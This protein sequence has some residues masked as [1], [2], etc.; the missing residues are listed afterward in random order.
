M[1][2]V[3]FPI[4]GS[5]VS[6]LS[7]SFYK[8]I[9]DVTNAIGIEVSS[10]VILNK[11]INIT[12][13][14]NKSNITNL[15]NDNLPTTVSKRRLIVNIEDEYNEDA[16]MSTVVNQIEN[17]FIFADHD[18]N[19]FIY[20]IF[21]KTDFNFEF[22]YVTPSISEANKIRDM[23]R[24]KLSQARNI[25]HHE[26]EYNIILPEIIEEFIA[27]VHENKKRLQNLS[28]EEYF[29][30][31]STKRVNL[32]TDLSN[33]ENSRIAYFEKQVRIVGTFDFIMPD[34][35]E[36][37]NETNNYKLT[38]NYKLSFDV[39]KG[40]TV[41]Y[42]V[43]VCNRPLKSKYIKFIED[44]K[45][46]S[47]EEYKKEL[48]YSLSLNS[49]SYFE[50]HRLLENRIDIKLPINVP[51]FD[52]YNERSIHKGYGI[53]YTFLVTIDETDKK[54]LLNLKKLGDYIFHPV[55]LKF[56]EDIE[57]DYCIEPY[58]SFIYIGLQ[59]DDFLFNLNVLQITNDLTI[60]SQIELPLYKPTRILISIILDLNM[61]NEKALERLINY[62]YNLFIAGHDI[63]NLPL[64]IL[65]AEHF[66]A[67]HNF[68]T[69][70]FKTS[71]NS[72]DITKIYLNI[73]YN[74]YKVDN[75]VFIE[76]FIKVFKQSDFMY[77]L[78]LHILKDNY[79]FLYDYLI[80]NK[81][82]DK[83]EIRNINYTEYRDSDITNMRTVM[84]YYL[85]A[86]RRS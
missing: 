74:F 6:I 69:E 18:I 8:I 28:L 47:L 39:P 14:D 45:V 85:V 48:S 34:K 71:L 15:E 12:P 55:I 68:K 7:P 41:R 10:R 61:I 5:Y 46:N 9:D 40:I 33:K 49:L 26:I 13:T 31:Y 79:T 84:T 35:I 82:I 17:R 80:S 23:I 58:Q 25:L 38:F 73:L 21:V 29:R 22:S 76:E 77:S 11:N 32:L 4:S 59:Q 57:K 36:I 67:I 1:P 3:H 2:V 62:S 43:M 52:D 78:F 54:T 56:I 24:I 64:F 37:D 16:L 81:I 75:K 65:L 53:L 72:S 30:T 50:A 51:M 83:N 27:D 42:P 60:K 66:R 86:E 63:H 44:N 70:Y 20:P 19:V